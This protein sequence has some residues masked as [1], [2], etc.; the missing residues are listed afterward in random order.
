[1]TD[2]PSVPDALTTHKRMCRA[3]EPATVAKECTWCD[4]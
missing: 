3:M 4:S 1:L 2:R